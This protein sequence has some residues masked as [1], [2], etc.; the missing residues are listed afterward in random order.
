MIGMR[1]RRIQGVDKASV[2][3]SMF[4]IAADLFLFQLCILYV[5]FVV[6]AGVNGGG[7]CCKFDDRK[8]QEQYRTIFS[9][10]LSTIEL[11][12]ATAPHQHAYPRTQSHTSIQQWKW[13]ALTTSDN[14]W[15]DISVYN[16]KYLNIV[17]CN[18]GKV[19][20]FF[21]ACGV[22]RNEGSHCRRRQYVNDVF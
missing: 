21:F 20:F 4:T 9:L 12:T 22:N 14:I 15:N 7:V 11:E 16:G 3:I 2:N 18:S 13:K 8:H 6:F 19:F 5:G 1:Q 10:S 17:D